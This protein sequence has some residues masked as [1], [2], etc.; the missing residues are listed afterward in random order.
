M[1]VCIV[2]KNNNTIRKTG[3]KNN[4]SSKAFPPRI[5]Y[6]LHDVCTVIYTGLLTESTTLSLVLHYHH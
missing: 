3:G 5:K 2:F 4:F 6:T 1:R